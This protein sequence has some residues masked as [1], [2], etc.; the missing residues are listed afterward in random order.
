MIWRKINLGIV[1]L[2]VAVMLLITAN[3]VFA[4]NSENNQRNTPAYK[5]SGLVSFLQTPMSLHKAVAFSDTADTSDTSSDTSSGHGY[6]V[7]TKFLESPTSLQQA[8][9]YSDTADTSDTSSNSSSGHGYSIFQNGQ[10]VNSYASLSQNMEPS[11]FM[12]S[13][14]GKQSAGNAVAMLAQDLQT[15][16]GLNQAQTN[17]VKTILINYL[18]S[19]H[20]SSSTMTPINKGNAMQKSDPKATAN[21][22]IEALLSNSQKST[23]STIRGDWWKEVDAKLGS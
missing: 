20:S 10:S 7:L 6:S 3:V 4:Y 21:L 17:S 19:P 12:Q 14:R 1:S 9:A 15:K 22:K 23:W 2:S 13:V 11:V 18:N 5:S 16:L 8:V